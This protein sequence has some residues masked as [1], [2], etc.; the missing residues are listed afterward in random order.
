[1]KENQLTSI[2]PIMNVKIIQRN[3]AESRFVTLPAAA[4]DGKGLL[5]GVDAEWYWMEGHLC[6][7]RKKREITK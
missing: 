6:I 1:M 5:S 2:H 3:N 4:A 7:R